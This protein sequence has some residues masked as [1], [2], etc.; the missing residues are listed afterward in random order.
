MNRGLSDNGGTVTRRTI[1]RR[2]AEPWGFSL[3][4]MMAVV[5][6]IAILSAIALPSYIKHVTKANRVAAEGCLSE[7][8]SYME[9]YYTTNLRYDQDST[10]TANPYIAPDCATVQQTGANYTYPAPAGSALTATTYTIT[11]VPVAGSAQAN[12]DTACG[13]LTLDQTGKRNIIGNGTGTVA[14]CW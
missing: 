14:T 5:A 3:I 9:R 4:E 7:M 1:G 10:A 8:A 2:T 11:A 12:R 6:I 13:T